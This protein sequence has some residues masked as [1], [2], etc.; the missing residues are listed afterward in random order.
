MLYDELDNTLWNDKCDYVEIEG[1]TNLNPN[2]YNLAVLQLNIRS[3][4][5]H[6]QELKHLLAKLSKHN[7]KIDVVL[8][9]ETFLS[10]NT[11]NMVNI[12]GYT[13]VGNYRTD[14]KGG[15]VSILLKNGI[16]Y[17]RRE[18]LDVFIEGKTESVFV[19]TISKCGKPIIM[20]SIYRPP[21]T[22]TLNNSAITNIVSVARATK[23]K[24]PC[25]IIL[26]MDHNVD[27]L[28]GN[29]HI[30]TYN[31]IENVTN[32]SLYPTI[33][34]PSRITHHSVMLI[35]NI[36]VSDQLHRS[37]ESMLLINDISD[38]LPTLALLKQT[39]LIKQ[40]PLIYKSRC[41]NDAKLKVVNHQLMRKDWIG[42][43]TGSTC[44]EK[45]DQLSN[46]LNEVLDEVAP[47]K[48]VR[49]SSKR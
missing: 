8:L 44:D 10:K 46:I 5:A 15:G 9:C 13:H 31:F 42:L 25:E 33:T 21:P 29:L 12:P 24:I 4:L 2:N 16:P 17:K 43:L 28:K 39:K 22:L 26:G 19:E 38:H 37:F 49:I 45:F 36:Y 7:C 6:Q 11:L 18:D 40:E 23:R 1:T 47:I 35:D 48:K 32:L 34:R 20:G 27:L 41:L 3:L 14:R 30:P